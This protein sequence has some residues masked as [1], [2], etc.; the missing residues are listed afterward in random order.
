MMQLLQKL[1]CFIVEMTK[2]FI[3]MVERHAGGGFGD[4]RVMISEE[5]V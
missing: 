3:C 5:A 4:L 1:V 2:C